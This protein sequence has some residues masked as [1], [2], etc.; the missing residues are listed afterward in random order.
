M[1][2]TAGPDSP[3]LFRRWFDIGLLLDRAQ[4]ACAAL[5]DNPSLSPTL[6]ARVFCLARGGDWNAAEIT[7]TLGNNVGS[8]SEEEQKLL[9]RFL[10]P[11]IF[12]DQPDPPIPDPLTPLDFLLREAVGLPR[13]AGP[14]PLAFLQSDL[15]PDMPMRGRIEA[16]E[17]L[18]LAGG[19]P[20][21]PLF[22]AY[23]AG[24]PA[25]SGGIWD[26]ARTVQAL[27][28][29]LAAGDP[30]A[31]AGALVRADA[32]LSERGLRSA[33]AHEYGTSLAGLD[34]G[35]LPAP[36]RATLAELLLLDGRTEVARAAAG[37]A[38]ASRIAA[39]LALAEGRSPA[40]SEDLRLAAAA[41][42]LSEAS[43]GDER[44]QGLAQLV[45]GGR[46]G[47]AI[48]AALDLV[49]AGETVDPQALRAALFALRRAGQEQAA[50]AIAL[51]TL[52]PG[53][54]G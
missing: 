3:D 45:D 51:E 2:E 34:P 35:P 46:Q 10:D 49:S 40:A 42:G 9:A 44:E 23:R 5:R 30:T 27:D 20:A 17:R 22:A 38:P 8:I 25:A 50:R 39:L 53:P 48:L 14:L 32:A 7:L 41:A 6:P 33:L 47:E 11:E 29:A 18:V 12:E 15:R 24:E 21:P 4:P 19:L 36:A 31:T 28:A 26:R 54:A 43:P 37:P 13:P 16:A 1:I 52:L